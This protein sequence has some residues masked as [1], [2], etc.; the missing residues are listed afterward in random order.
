VTASNGQ[1]LRRTAS[2]SNIQIKE[3]TNEEEDD[4]EEFAYMGKNGAKLSPEKIR[5]LKMKAL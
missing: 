4:D 2:F 5:Q 3:A 1:R